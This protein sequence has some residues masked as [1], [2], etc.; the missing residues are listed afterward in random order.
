MAFPTVE[1]TETQWTMHGK[2]VL[3]SENITIMSGMVVRYYIGSTSEVSASR[4]GVLSDVNWQVS[5]AQ[6]I[7]TLHDVI[8]AAWA[9]AQRLSREDRYGGWVRS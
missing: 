4:D 5:T 6:D 8:D 2:P 9:D 7:Q 3:R 1:R